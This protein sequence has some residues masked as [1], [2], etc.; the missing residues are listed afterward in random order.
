MDMEREK[1]L[2][3]SLLQGFQRGWL[4]RATELI[5]QYLE[6]VEE[7]AFQQ[8][9]RVAE[10]AGEFLGRTAAELLAWFISVVLGGR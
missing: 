7:D 8:M 3:S 4:A 2:L 9:L 5:R 1:R 6:G 10:D